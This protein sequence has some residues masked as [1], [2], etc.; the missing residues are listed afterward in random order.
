MSC[1]QQNNSF[2]IQKQKADESSPFPR[3]SGIEKTRE[4]AGGFSFRRPGNSYFSAVFRSL[5]K[6][7]LPSRTRKWKLPPTIVYDS[8]K[9]PHLSR[10]SAYSGPLQLDVVIPVHSGAGRHQLTDNYV[11]LQAQQR[12]NLPLIAASVSTLVVS[13]KEAAVQERIGSQRRLGDTQQGRRTGGLPADPAHR[14]RFWHGFPHWRYRIRSFPPGSLG[15]QQRVA[16]I[17]HPDLLHHLAYDNLD[18]AYR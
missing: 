5:F 7:D 8:T 9:T 15:I 11:L 13:W 18:N 16:L 3:P 4:P 2:R 17:V 6:L 14:L 1:L 10:D 12:V